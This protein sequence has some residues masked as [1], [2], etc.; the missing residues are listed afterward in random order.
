MYCENGS[1]LWGIKHCISIFSK[2]FGSEMLVKYLKFSMFATD[3]WI[4][5]T[6]G[7]LMPSEEKYK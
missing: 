4:L 2:T 5:E 7:L 1:S 3:I 6:S